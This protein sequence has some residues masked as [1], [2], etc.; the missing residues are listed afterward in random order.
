MSLDSPLVSVIIPAFNCETFLPEAVESV[1]EQSYQ[2][3]EIIIVDDGSTDGTPCLI[4]SL[5]TGIKTS[6]QTNQGPA[7]ARNSGLALAKGEF[8]AFL[9]ADDLWT[10]GKIEQQLEHFT[11]EPQTQVVVGA[12]QRVR[13]A[14]SNNVARVGPGLEPVGPVWM[15]F[16][17]GATLI[18]R[19]VFDEVG[20]FDVSLRQG[21][22]VDW[23]MRAREA[24]VSIG[25]SRE[26]VQWYRM[27][28]SNL[29]RV[30]KDKDRYFLAAM[31]KSID[32]RRATSRK[33]MDLPAVPGLS[34]FMP[35]RKVKQS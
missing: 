28:E 25:I 8:I 9:D 27:H 18:R 21:E 24:G 19:E 2:S 22:D 6:R 34:D 11:G 12:T 13:A 5:G 30:K 26:L 32:R 33:A 31:K 23:F 35:Q 10:A 15:L 7:A 14:R 16:S 3:L 4:E 17:L 1:R 29:T 20:W